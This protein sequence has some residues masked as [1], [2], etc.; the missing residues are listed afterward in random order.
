MKRNRLEA[1]KKIWTRIFLLGKKKTEF[2]TK[3]NKFRAMS[4]ESRS[5]HGDETSHRLLFDIL[6]H[7]KILK[8]EEISRMN[9]IIEKRN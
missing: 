4:P 8:K 3:Q 9:R 7:K 1:W 2:F 6:R 5:M